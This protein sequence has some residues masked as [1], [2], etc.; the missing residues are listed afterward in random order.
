MF[1]VSKIEITEDIMLI[2][3]SKANSSYFASV[4]QKLSDAG[5]VIDMISQTAPAGSDISFSFTSSFENFDEIIRTLSFKKEQALSPMISGGY[6]KVNLFGEEMVESVGVAAKALNALAQAD[7]DVAMI[8]TSDLD[9]SIL[10][11]REDDDA[12]ASL[13]QTTFSL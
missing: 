1:G 4:L 12:T 11:R 10:V 6:S 7:I 13:L 9:I 3:Y 5:I 2:S 8:T